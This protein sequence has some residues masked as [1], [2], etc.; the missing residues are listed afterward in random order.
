MPEIVEKELC[1]PL[2]TPVEGDDGYISWE[3]QERAP[4]DEDGVFTLGA[5]MGLGVDQAHD[6]ERDYLRDVMRHGEKVASEEAWYAL[7]EGRTIL[8]LFDMWA[9]ARTK[10]YGALK[11][12]PTHAQRDLLSTIQ[13]YGSRDEACNIVDLKARQVGGTQGMVSMFATLAPK[14]E[15]AGFLVMAHEESKALGIYSRIGEQLAMQPFRP[16]VTPN[17]K[18]NMDKFERS[19]AVLSV[20]SAE[21]KKPGHSLAFRYVLLSEYALYPDPQRI[22]KGVNATLPNRGHYVKVIETTANGIANDFFRIWNATV[23]GDNKMIAK[24][25]SWIGHHLYRMRIL[26]EEDRQRVH[27]RAQ[28]TLEEEYEELIQDSQVED[29]QLKW[30]LHYLENVQHG[31]L[32]AMHENMPTTPSQAFLSSGRPVF[33]ARALERAVEVAK[34]LDPVFRGDIVDLAHPILS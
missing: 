8:E 18:K 10:D 14:V 3:R 7:S 20:E 29:E 6:F 25:Y 21:S 2:E 1:M 28:K 5:F 11:L 16:R 34:D 31:D 15:G 9:W 27:D 22:I 33:S 32:D 4:L 19:G 13:D 30:Y 12:Q 24:F 23:R 17:R 26:N